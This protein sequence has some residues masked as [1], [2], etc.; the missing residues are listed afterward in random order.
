MRNYVL[1]ILTALLLLGC[2][3]RTS[4]SNDLDTTQLDTAFHKAE[5]VL[6]QLLMPN[7]MARSEPR[8]D[9]EV[10]GLLERFHELSRMFAEYPDVAV[11]FL[12]AKVSTTPADRQDPAVCALQLLFEINN[13]AAH[14]AILD[15]QMHPHEV[16]FRTANGMLRHGEDCLWGFRQL[17][18]T[19]HAAMRSS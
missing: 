4:T 2:I 6:Y 18:R 19:K 3:A 13:G 11:P 14:R 17:E 15:A 5:K 7:S 9:A 8:T 1:L 12:S 16:V 10:L